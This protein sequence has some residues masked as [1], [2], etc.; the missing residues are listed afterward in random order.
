M[1]KVNHNIVEFESFI[2]YLDDNYLDGTHRD[3]ELKM[4]KK[5]LE[6]ARLILDH[7]LYQ[8]RVKV[9]RRELK[10][11]ESGFETEGQASTYLKEVDKDEFI[12]K[13]CELL[14]EYQATKRWFMVFGYNVL[15]DTAVIPFRFIPLA[16][17]MHISDDRERLVL[18]IFKDTTYSD[19]KEVWGVIRQQQHGL[20]PNTQ[21]DSK[22]KSQ[23][24]V[25]NEEAGSF[26]LINT[27]PARGT[28]KLSSLYEKGKFILDQTEKGLTY[29]EIA[30]KISSDNELTYKDVAD[31][32]YKY[33]NILNDLYLN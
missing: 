2:L 8:Q 18:E 30:P 21:T 10:I 28:N 13:V 16:M 7:V 11:P 32:V 19:L 29:E 6:K 22:Y 20:K 24:K 3:S 27:G 5:Q 9:L 26:D 14:E 1:K 17:E 4:L 31:Y 12:T 15:I 25:W 33:K 23:A